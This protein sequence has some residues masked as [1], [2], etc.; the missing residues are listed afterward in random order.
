MKRTIVVSCLLLGLVLA[1]FAIAFASGLVEGWKARYN[2]PTEDM[3][4]SLKN[5]VV[6]GAGN[7]YVTG[8]ID[9]HYMYP[10]AYATVKYDTDGNEQWVARYED[11]SGNYLQVYPAAVALDSS[12]NVY[13]TGYAYDQDYVGFYATVKYDNDGNELWVAEYFS[14]ENYTSYAYAMAVDSSGNVYVTGKSYGGLNSEGINTGY[15]YVTV[16]YDT[17]GNELWVARYAPGWSDDTPKAV[18][19]DDLGNVYVTGTSKIWS[20]GNDYD[21][22][23]VKYDTDGNELWAARYNGTGNGNDGAYRIALDSAGNTFITGWSQGDGTNYDCTTVKYDQG[24]NEMW[25]ARYDGPVSGHDQGY[26]L[27]VDDAGDV[28][29]GGYSAGDGTGDD[30]LTIKYDEHGTE[31]WVARYNGASPSGTDLVWDLVLD[32]S[33]NVY[34][35][36]YTNG[37]INDNAVVKYDQ[38]GNEVCVAK[39]TS[40]VDYRF[41]AYS[42]G[43]DSEGNVYVAG[44]IEDDPYYTGLTRYLVVKYLKTDDT[45]G[46]GLT[47]EDEINIYLTDPDDPDTDGDGLSDGDEALVHATNPLDMDTD[48]DGVVDGE[49]IANGWDPLDPNDPNAAPVAHSKNVMT[50]EDV[51]QHIDGIAG[52]ANGDALDYT[53]LDP[54]DHGMVTFNDDYSADYYP[55]ENYFGTDFFSFTASDGNADSNAATIVITINPVNDPPQA[56]AEIIDGLLDPATNQTIIAK[57]VTFHGTATDI[58]SPSGSLT[59]EWLFSD[60]YPMLPSQTVTR[61]FLAKGIHTATLRVRDD[62]G[63]YDETQIDIVVE[64]A[65]GVIVDL[66]VMVESFNLQQ[67]ITNSLDSK[68]NNAL[69]TLDAEKAGN[70][71]DAI[72]KIQAFINSVEAQR[73][74][75]L[76]NEQADELISFANDI[77]NS[78]TES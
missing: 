42:L 15:D 24:G 4:A 10:A 23:T 16:K 69:A 49:E 43:L 74:K 22:A 60:G 13:V 5:M 27:V 26:A 11:P 76:T 77:I 46:D 78:L 51:E 12:G 54:P 68:L 70:R 59:Y 75:E 47:D 45:D 67:G 3:L 30:Y 36:G 71:S 37:S 21:Y 63:A 52:D 17:D 66:V 6:D 20:S 39:F 61:A 7:V 34:V 8:S 1:F 32:S 65:S 72:N 58:D 41:I 50:D 56:F 38:D 9:P 64:D 73:D 19:V 33:K 25:V 44:S 14:E 28:C 40:D 18:T 53:L 55:E 57:E 48:G 2:P 62:A 31:L 29:V 35:A